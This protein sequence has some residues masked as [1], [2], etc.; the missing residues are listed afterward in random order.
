MKPLW[1][2]NF[3]STVV[4][5]IALGGCASHWTTAWSI[6][7]SPPSPLEVVNFPTI[8]SIAEGQLGTTLAAYGVKSKIPALRLLEPWV[9][10]EESKLS[11]A[12]FLLPGT[13]KRTKKMTYIG[14]EQVWECFTFE[15][16]RTEHWNMDSWGADYAKSGEADLCRDRRGD[17]HLVNGPWIADAKLAPRPVNFDANYEEITVEELNGPTDVQEFVYNGRVGDAVKFVYREF[18]N[19]YARPAFTQ[20]VQYDLSQSDEIG[21]QD[22]RIK[23]LEATNTEI[24]YIVLKA[25]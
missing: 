21:F 18:K 5:A 20:E 24:S 16:G 25:F 10:V 4:I 22:L 12:Y 17:F 13:G 8:G 15:F 6:D 19:S 14:T 7:N 2:L 1:S 23:V 9:F 11:A 3:L